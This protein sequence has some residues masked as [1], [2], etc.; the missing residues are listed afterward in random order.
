MRV[1]LFEGDN[2]SIDHVPDVY[3]SVSRQEYVY[4]TVFER[5]IPLWRHVLPS[6]ASRTPWLEYGMLPLKWCVMFLLVS[7]GGDHGAAN[8]SRWYRRSLLYA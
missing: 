1:C 2:G 3:M 6:S 5:A 8:S 7:G 4:Q